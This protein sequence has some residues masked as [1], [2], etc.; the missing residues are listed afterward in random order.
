MAGSRPC[1]VRSGGPG[2]LSEPTAGVTEPM[3]AA[4]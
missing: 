1:R 4:V 3:L 2:S